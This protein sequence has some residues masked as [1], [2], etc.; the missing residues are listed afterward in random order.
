MAGLMVRP[1][2]QNV[3][4]AIKR[5]R[6][7]LAGQVLKEGLNSAPSKP[8]DGRVFLRE[9]VVSQISDSAGDTS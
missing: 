8:I 1:L 3:D 5:S 6:S 4:H 2:H 7:V 9:T